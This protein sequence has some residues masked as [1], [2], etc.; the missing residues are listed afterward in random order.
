[1]SNSNSSKNNKFTYG[2][3][4]LEGLSHIINGIRGENI[5]YNKLIENTNIF[6]SNEFNRKTN[7]G[8]IIKENFIKYLKI[9]KKLYEYHVH[10]ENLL[11]KY[12]EEYQNELQSLKKTNIKS[13]NGK[14]LN[15]KEIYKKILYILIRQKRKVKRKL[16]KMESMING[17]FQ[18]SSVKNYTSLDRAFSS[19]KNFPGINFNEKTKEAYLKKIKSW[20]SDEKILKKIDMNIKESV[21]ILKELKKEI[22]EQYVNIENNASNAARNAASNAASNAAR[23]AVSNSARNAA[24]NAASNAASNLARNA[25]RNGNN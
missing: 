14:E 12:G 6:L 4:L 24:R 9:L 15:S 25:A 10:Y 23:N 8:A 7:E 22:N 11:N 17:P 16:N 21:K 19:N 2:K 13:N 18:I 3:T 1:M 20:I 5:T